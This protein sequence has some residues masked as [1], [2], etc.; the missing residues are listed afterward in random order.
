[1]GHVNEGEGG[2]CFIL[3]CTEQTP[4]SLLWL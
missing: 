3:I 2:E 1:M 4:L